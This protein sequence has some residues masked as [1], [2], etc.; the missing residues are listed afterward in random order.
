MYAVMY[1]AIYADMYADIMNNVT[2]HKAKEVMTTECWSNIKEEVRKIPLLK[3]E[4]I[5]D[6]QSLSGLDL[7][8]V[9]IIRKVISINDQTFLLFDKNLYYIYKILL[10][11]KF[12]TGQTKRPYFYFPKFLFS[13]AKHCKRPN[14]S[15]K[16]D[17]LVFKN[18]TNFF[19]KYDQHFQKFVQ[20][21]VEIQYK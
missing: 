21:T 4:M 13:N 16:S 20:L 15:L 18:V 17:Q 5:A 2:I 8:F 7:S 10:K 12:S 1:A 9:K 6:T 14:E 19:G 3:N 11:S